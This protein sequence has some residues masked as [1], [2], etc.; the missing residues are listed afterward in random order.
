M[1]QQP[2]YFMI[3]E[4]ELSGVHVYDIIQDNNEDYWVATDNGLYY[5]DYYHFKKIDCPIMT[6]SSVFNLV[7][8]Q[9][10]ELFCNNLSGQIFKIEDQTCKLYYQIP[11]SLMHH[12]IE[13]S[14]DNQ[15][16]LTVLNRGIFQIDKDKKVNVLR[17]K[18]YDLLVGLF[19]K[20]DS[21]G[22]YFINANTGDILRLFNG[23]I[24]VVSSIGKG[25]RP[26][27]ISNEK[28]F[29]VFDQTNG[30]LKMLDSTEINEDKSYPMAGP[31]IYS[32]GTNIWK[33]SRKG[34]A[35]VYTENMQPKFKESLVL[36]EYFLSAMCADK[37]GNI[38]IGTFG[39][40]IVVIPEL[41]TEMIKIPDPKERASIIKITKQGHLYIGCRSG[42]VF[43]YNEKG[44]NLVSSASQ[45]GIEYLEFLEDE[46]CIIFDGLVSKPSLVYYP[47]TK[48]TDYF[49]LNA[50]KDIKRLES[51]KYITASNVGCYW[52]YPKDKINVKIVGFD[53]RTNCVGYE[54]TT[55][56]IYAGTSGGLRIGREGEVVKF[57]LND[58]PIICKKIIE[59]NEKMFI[60]TQSNGVLLFKNGE[61]VDNWNKES[62]LST[63]NVL[64]IL[65]FRSDY[66]AST[67]K[68][69]L[70]L[71]S[72]GKQLHKFSAAEG[73]SGEQANDIELFQE[74]LYVVNKDAIRVIDLKNSLKNAV[75]KV[76]LKYWEIN[77]QAQ[78]FSE[79][80][81][82]YKE[83]KVSFFFTS[84]SLQNKDETNYH[85]KLSGIDEVWQTHVF[86]D[87]VVTYKTI[88]PGEYA[89]EYYA[90]IG[91]I[92][93]EQK[94]FKFEISKPFWQTVWFFVVCALLFLVVT[95]VVYRFQVN[96]ITKVNKIKRE[97]I[98]SKLTAIQSQMNP[99]FIFNSLN[100]IQDLVL[101]QDGEK[102]Y[103]YLSKFAF[104]VRKV[105]HYSEQDFIRLEDEVEMLKV[106]L[107]LEKLRFDDDFIFEIK[108]DTAEEVEIPP[109][110]IQPF[111]ENAI[112]HGLLHRPGEKRLTINFTLNGSVI[113]C[114][115]EDN[116]IG[117]ERSKEI[118][119]RKSKKHQSFSTSSIQHRFEI[120]RNI[121]GGEL[122]LNY[123][124]LKSDN[125]ATG[126]RL[127]INIPVRSD[128]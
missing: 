66:I 41:K 87:N 101:Q 125:V 1:S 119:Q 22:L 106:Y 97:M 55:G 50:L 65:P 109:L 26:F 25:H 16:K 89:F 76:E 56:L 110:I 122:G 99:H 127:T 40:G 32:D 34:G 62:G 13:I 77:D 31:L 6:S 2:S 96:R 29:Y 128:Y 24:D 75:P 10:G 46:K 113:I 60:T 70:L 20:D 84:K 39:D 8:N 118:N 9:K 71:S 93:G 120:L 64:E 38:L 45:K 5:Y 102:A 27:A 3:G 115:I 61:L 108:V 90:S 104:L 33:A 92:D 79:N 42:K 53:S 44:F 49:D 63:N 95:Y 124:D 30:E 47:E 28:H 19:T 88:P 17:A 82:T 68:G 117:R 81:L 57:E 12:E 91:E 54:S 58:K 51:G 18:G 59:I 14:F 37:E 7:Q 94:T 100:S 43:E 114:T 121:H 74:F 105:L 4:D 36:D 111:V 23:K 80:S 126:T 112:K 107:D 15:D 48:T 72:E 11:D 86:E 52:F 83:N 78:N 35:R 67:D 73:L 103:S 123:E 116:G 85:F 21:G 98:E 69:I